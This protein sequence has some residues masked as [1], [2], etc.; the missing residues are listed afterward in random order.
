MRM[1]TPA[2]DEIELPAHVKDLPI[3]ILY[4]VNEAD[5]FRWLTDR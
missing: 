5:V 2:F 3:A 1:S 4:Q